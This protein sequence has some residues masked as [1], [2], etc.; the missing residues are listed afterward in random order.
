MYIVKDLHTCI[1]FKSLTLAM[2]VLMH[3]IG[4]WEKEQGVWAESLL[5]G[6][7]VSWSQNTLLW[8]WPVPV[9][10]PCECDDRGCHMVGYFSKVFYSTS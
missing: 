5:L 7:I 9:N 10:M 6:K 4:W 2:W 8:C 3:E 1:F